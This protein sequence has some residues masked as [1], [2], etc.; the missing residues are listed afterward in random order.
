MLPGIP[1]IQ[2]VF[3]I[4]T[5]LPKTDHYETDISSMFNETQTVDGT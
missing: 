5:E 1:K 2:D 3:P 4:E